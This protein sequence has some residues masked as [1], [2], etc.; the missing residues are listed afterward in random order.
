MKIVACILFTT[1]K[2]DSIQAVIDKMVKPYRKE[3][4]Y[5]AKRLRPMWVDYDAA[6]QKITNKA[7]Q[8]FHSWRQDKE[9][10]IEAIEADLLAGKK[11][12]IEMSGFTEDGTPLMGAGCADLYTPEQYKL[13]EQE[14]AA[15]V[16][17]FCN[18]TGYSVRTMATILNENQKNGIQSGSET[19]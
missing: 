18:N 9:I 17:K 10:D 15:S 2:F 5:I 14:S 16:Q 11:V 8:V 6:Y 13:Q 1:G 7:G 19:E 3:P 4:D 12:R